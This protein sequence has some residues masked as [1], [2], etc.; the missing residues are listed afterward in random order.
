MVRYEDLIASRG[1]EL[2]KFFP[3]A[4]ALDE[5]LSS[6][7]VN[8]FYDRPLMLD[9]GERLLGRSGVIWDYYS[10]SD[11]EKLIAEVHSATPVSSNP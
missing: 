8:K 2:A 5:N 11:V 1:K 7:N 4:A 10:K 3:G 6:K 9:L